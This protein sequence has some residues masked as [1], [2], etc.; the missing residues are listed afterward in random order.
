MK[1]L[2]IVATLLSL[3]GCASQIQALSAAD[4]SAVVAA[5]AS[6]DLGVK[7]VTQ[8]FCSMSV[9]TLNR[10]PE[11]VQ[12]VKDICWSNTTTTASDAAGQIGKP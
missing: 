1:K 4:A 12:A 10:H 3:T 7:V 11:Y 8:Q 2:L 5:R 9:D 6:A